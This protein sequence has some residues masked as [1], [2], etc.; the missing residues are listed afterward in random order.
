[1]SIQKIKLRLRIVFF[2]VLVVY[3]IILFGFSYVS[4]YYTYFAI[5]TLA[6]SALFGFGS[7][8][9][10]RLTAIMVFVITLIAWIV[11]LLTVTYTGVYLS[12]IAIPI[13]LISGV[14]ALSDKDKN[15]S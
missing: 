13:L 15:L 7:F 4:V 5:P 8:K 12:L 9:S 10:P 14:I 3:T 1:M 6:I 11:T 2:T